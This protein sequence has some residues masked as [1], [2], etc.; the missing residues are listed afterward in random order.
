MIV[1][2]RVHAAHQAQVV[3]LLRGLRQQ[4]RNVNA[5]HRGGNRAERATGRRARLGVPAFQ[6]AESA[7]HVEHDDSFLVGAQLVGDRRIGEHAEPAGDRPGA[8]RRQ[9]AEKLP[10]RDAMFR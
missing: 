8:R 4:L 6:L 9:R 10:P 5:R 1:F 7:V 3:H 2:A